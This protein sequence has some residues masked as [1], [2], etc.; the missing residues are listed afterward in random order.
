V[1]VEGSNPFARSIFST[2][3]TVPDAKGIKSKWRKPLII[4]SLALLILIS[5]LLIR[6][7][8]ILAVIF[9]FLKIIGVS[10]KAI[11]GIPAALKDVH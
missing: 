4:F 11:L 5:V 6:A 10:V 3:D 2:V 9:W 1:S 7:S 8:L